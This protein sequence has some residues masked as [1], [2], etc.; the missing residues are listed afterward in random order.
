MIKTRIYF[1]TLFLLLSSCTS[2][3]QFKYL[4]EEYEVPTKVFDS[5]YSEGWQA[6]L[7]IMKKYDLKEQSQEL[8]VVKTRWIDNTIELNFADSFGGKDS[9]KGAKFILSIS[10]VKGYQRGRE[11]VRVGVSKRQMVEQDFLQ[12]WKIVPTDGILEKTILYR[13][14]KT[15]SIYKNLKYLEKI[16]NKNEE[17]KEESEDF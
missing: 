1:F 7:E 10:V 11:V 12:G 3:E 9:V 16:K 6:V 14:G 5:T 8:G 4:T 2:Y 15:L 17:N 13:I